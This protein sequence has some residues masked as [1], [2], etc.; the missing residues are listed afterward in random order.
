MN[1]PHPI[2][3]R[4]GWPFLAASVLLSVVVSYWCW[5]WALPLWLLSL[6]ILQFFRDPP[7]E[8]PTQANA[9]VSAAD[10]KVIIV[11]K[12]YDDY[13]KRDALKISVF[14]NVFNVHSN[15]SR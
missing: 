15:R 5:L 11:E 10:G 7:R 9:V 8:V 1:Y 13:L 2:I 6:F 4:E 12:A 14:M 3:A